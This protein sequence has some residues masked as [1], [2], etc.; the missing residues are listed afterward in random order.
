MTPMRTTFSRRTVR[1]VMCGPWRTPGARTAAGLLL[2]A[3][4]WG[5]RVNSWRPER[6][7]SGR[8][9]DEAR[10]HPRSC[11]RLHV[12]RLRGGGGRRFRGFPLQDLAAR[13][14]GRLNAAE[15]AENPASGSEQDD[16]DR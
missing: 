16:E 7:H 8:V 9:A 3:A 4:G 10:F 6:R 13:A 1:A 14:R 5:M 12:C 15:D 2:L 11:E